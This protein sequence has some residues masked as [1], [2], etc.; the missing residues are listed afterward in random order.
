MFIALPL[1]LNNNISIYDFFPSVNDVI[2]D[3]MVTSSS[4]E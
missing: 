4:I 1:A 3:I 2:E